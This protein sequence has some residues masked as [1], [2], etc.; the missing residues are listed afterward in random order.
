MPGKRLRA[1]SVW[2]VSWRRGCAGQPL[3]LLGRARAG[4]CGRRAWCAACRRGPSGA[5]CRRSTP[6]ARAASPRVRSA[7]LRSLAARPRRG[8]GPRA[9]SSTF[10]I[11][12][13]AFTRSISARAPANASPRCGAEAATITDGSLS[14]TRPVRWTSATAHSPWRAASSSPIARSF[15]ARHLDVGLVV[16]RLDVAGDALEARRRRRRAGRARRPRPRRDRA[17]RSV[18]STS[19]TARRRRSPAGSARPRRSARTGASAPAYS[20]LSATMHWPGAA[21]PPASPIAAS[22][23][24]T[25]RAVGQLE[26]DAIGARPLAQAGEQAHGDPHRGDASCASSSA[27]RHRAAQVIPLHVVAVQRDQ[28]LQLLGRLDA[29]GH[30]AQPERAGPCRRS[31]HDRGSSRRRRGRR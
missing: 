1:D 23:S 9:V 19:R 25:T 14:G 20:R 21:R 22:T 11:G 3:D 7:T 15:V 27:R 31:R 10:Q 26:L 30:R 29:L 17:A 28:A 12:A 2:P 18:T 4:G 13:S 8:A 16:E 24:A 6:S 5:A